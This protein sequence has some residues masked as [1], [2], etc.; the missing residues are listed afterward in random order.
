M[1][2]LIGIAQHANYLIK[3]RRCLRGEISCEHKDHTRCDFGK[4]WY[5]EIL[6]NLSY[7]P[8]DAKEIIKKK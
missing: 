7:F 4:W 2:H 8:E 1:K 5:G 3:I 6:S